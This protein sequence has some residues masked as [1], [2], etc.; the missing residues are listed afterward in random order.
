MIEVIAMLAAL[1]LAAIVLCSLGRGETA[2][3]LGFFAIPAAVCGL[4]ARARVRS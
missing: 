4:D 1:A 2:I 3:A